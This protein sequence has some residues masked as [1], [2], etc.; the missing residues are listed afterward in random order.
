MGYRKSNVRPSAQHKIQEG[1]NYCLEM[2]VESRINGL[3][4]LGGIVASQK[5]GAC[6]LCIK[7]AALFNDLLKVRGLIQVDSTTFASDMHSEELIQFS[8]VLALPF[9][10]ELHLDRINYGLVRATEEGII[11]IY[12][13]NNHI[14]ACQDH[15]QLW[16]L[17]RSKDQLDQK[18][19]CSTDPARTLCIIPGP[20]HASRT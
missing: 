10:H 15:V 11:N 17:V 5:W 6:G 8:E 1:P 20:G 18:Y 4:V 19:S 2:G 7:H 3:C 16:S 9:A 13:P 12:D 14:G